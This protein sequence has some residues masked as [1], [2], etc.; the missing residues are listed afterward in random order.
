MSDNVYEE[1]ASRM[2]DDRQNNNKKKRKVVDLTIEDI[3]K[4]EKRLRAKKRR[5]VEHIRALE[6]QRQEELDRRMADKTLPMCGICLDEDIKQTTLTKCGHTF[7]T[8]CLLTM[9]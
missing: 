1:L 9:L 5:I 4:R 2:F 6:K 7:C 8:V 3:Q